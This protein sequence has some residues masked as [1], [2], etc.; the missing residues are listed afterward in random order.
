[1]Q[2]DADLLAAFRATGSEAAFAEIHARHGAL[3]LRTCLR[4]LGDMQ[5]AEDAAQ[6]AFLMLAQRPAAVQGSLASWLYYAARKTAY[7]ARR[8]RQRRNLREE[9]AAIMQPAMSLPESRELREEIDLALE[10]LP[11]SLR[12]AVLLCH[13]EGRE[14]LDAARQAGCSQA[15]MSR[16]SSEGLQQLGDILRRRG[17]PLGAAGLTAWLATE[18]SAAVPLPP[19]TVAQLAGHTQAASL[20]Q[21]AWRTLFWSQVKMPV[22]AGLLTFVLM[23]TTTGLLWA[24][25]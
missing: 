10:R 25:R 21:T 9:T 7:V 16:R 6:A 24:W 12:E 19:L 15:T 4:A 1:M 18:A 17:L 5:E 20:A 13:L 11:E 14:Q 22:A 3:V 2:A 23:G 8:S